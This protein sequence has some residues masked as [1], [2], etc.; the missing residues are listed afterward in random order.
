MTALRAA[1]VLAS[2][3]VCLGI[4]TPAGARP[5]DAGAGAAGSRPA[6][7][8]ALAP[9]DDDTVLPS[10]VAI[11]MARAE[12]S[13]ARTEAHVDDGEPVQAV[14]SL[15]VVRQN[16]ARADKAAR[17]QMTAVPA[18]PEAEEEETTA[19]DSVVAVLAL[20]QDVVLRIADLF[21]MQEGATVTALASTI[22][23]AQQT[24]SRLVRDIVALDPEAAGA[25]YADGMADS[26]DGYADEV[27]NLTEALA[28]DSLAPESVAA[29]RTALN[30]SRATQARL[31]SAFGGG[32]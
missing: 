30:R 12:D 25:D 8:A 6:E 28:D 18:D 14:V 3:V 2:I 22:S 17:R 11:P 5:A 27:D 23:L 32:E 26:L 13:M 21:H 29:L 16:L 10:R 1:H 7:L 15:Q 4:A 31:A 24:R 19:P 9:P 20:D